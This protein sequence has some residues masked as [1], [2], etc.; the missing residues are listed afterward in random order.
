MIGNSRFFISNNSLY[1]NDILIGPVNERNIIDLVGT[2]KARLYLNGDFIKEI[3]NLSGDLIINTKNIKYV[4]SY[5]MLLTENN[6]I[7]NYNKNRSW[8]DE[9]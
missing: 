4:K 8:L 6:I 9:E 2:N 7:N 3:D 5:D 1:L